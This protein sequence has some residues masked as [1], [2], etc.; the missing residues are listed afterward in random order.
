MLTGMTLLFFFLFP[1]KVVYKGALGN[2]Q[3]KYMYT[4]YFHEE[5]TKFFSDSTFC[6]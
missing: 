4:E 2:L 3:F 6:Y 1:S 5:L